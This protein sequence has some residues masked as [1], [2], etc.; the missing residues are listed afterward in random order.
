MGQHHITRKKHTHANKT[1]QR[2]G[3]EKLMKVISK[4]MNERNLNEGQ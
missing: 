2:L 3:E 1:R 4:A